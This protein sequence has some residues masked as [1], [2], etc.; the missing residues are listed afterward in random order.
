MAAARSP[1]RSGVRGFVWAVVAAQVL[2]Q[3]GAFTL[4]A[5]LPGYIAR[6]DLSKIEAGWLLGI[7]FAAYVIAVPVLV[8]L[9]V[10]ADYV[11]GWEKFG[12]FLAGEEPPAIEDEDEEEA[13]EIVEAGS[14]AE[15]QSAARRVT[16]A[17]VTEEKAGD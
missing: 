14:G 12:N 16:A 9:R 3:V 15:D 5:L 11:P 13:R 10:L 17:V 6:W 8:V 1:D 4:P 7:F 2:V